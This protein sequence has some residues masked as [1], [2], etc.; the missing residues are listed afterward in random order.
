MNDL[1]ISHRNQAVVEKIIKSIDDEYEK[2]LLT[3]E[4]NKSMQEWYSSI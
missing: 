1:K 4:M 2:R 3:E